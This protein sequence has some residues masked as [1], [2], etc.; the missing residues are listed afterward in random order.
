MSKNKPGDGGPAFPTEVAVGFVP[1]D[2]PQE[3]KQWCA[4]RKVPMNGMSLW[5]YF[6]A[7]IPLNFV[8]WGAFYEEEKHTAVQRMAEMAGL[9]ADAL[10]AE[11]KRRFE[12]AE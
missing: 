12:D 1:S 5:D 4:S 11:R 2:A 8:F 3:V 9:Y 10:L 7:H 6:A